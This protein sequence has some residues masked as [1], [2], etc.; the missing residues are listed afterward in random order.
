MIR[1]EKFIPLSFSKLAIIT[2]FIMTFVDLPWVGFFNKLKYLFMAIVFAYVIYNIRY[3]SGS[4]ELFKSSVFIFIFIVDAF[5]VSWLNFGEVETVVPVIHCVRFCGTILANFLLLIV[6]KNKG[7]IDLLLSVFCKLFIL[8]CILADITIVMG[9]KRD[10]YY[11]VGSKFAVAY[12]HLQMIV[13]LLASVKKLKPKTLFLVAM[14]LI[15]TMVINSFTGCATGLVGTVVFALFLIL[16]FK[17]V[18]FINKP[19]I[20]IITL[21]VC[22]LF[23]FWYNL[24]L[25]SSFAQFFI[26][27]ILHKDLNLTNRTI[28]YSKI[29]LLFGESTVWGYGISSN[30]EMCMRWGIPN[31]QNGILKVLMETGAI[32]AV[33]I[34]GQYYSVFLKTRDTNTISIKAM[35]AYL[36]VM[37]I[38]SSIE[39]TIGF[40]TL[41]LLM[42][43]LILS[44][45]EKEAG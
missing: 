23:P 13:F 34:I 44:N 30:Y 10:G 16:S 42:Y 32:G 26:V 21:L 5:V 25:N 18:I 36:L 15:E 27:N 12:I 11:I 24:L 22:A 7:K 8:V 19:C 9:I 39:I 40:A 17:E 33:M 1:I 43:N 14:L 37:S 41:T 35:S 3:L 4:N 31:I 29:P 28:I 38:L 2:C 20:Q 45:A 6:L